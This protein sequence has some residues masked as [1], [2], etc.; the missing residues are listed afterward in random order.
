MANTA[1]NLYPVLETPRGFPDPDMIERA[2]DEADFNRAVQSYRFFYPTVSFASVYAGPQKIGAVPNK[3]FGIL[4]GNPTQLVFTA[5]SDTPYATVLLDLTDSPAVIELPPGPLIGV[6]NDLNQR[7]VM[8]LGVPGP[9]AGKGGKHVII[10]PDY[11]GVIPENH[12][13]GHSTTRRLI[14]AV[15]VIPENGDIEAAV[16]RMKDIKIT[17]LASGVR[18]GEQQ[19]VD[20][21]TTF[22]DTTPLQ[23]ENN[24]RFWEVLHEVIDAEPAFEGYRNQYGE[25][26]ALGIEKGKPFSPDPRMKGILERAAKSGV[27]QM[28]VQAFADRR[29][30][31]V[32]WKDRRWE[33]LCLRPDTTSF[34]TP[35]FTDLSAREKWFYQAIL[36]SPAMTRRKVGSGSVY[37]LG[38]RDKNG[39]WLDG[40]K[41]YKLTVPLPV[42]AK[43]FWSVTVYDA[44]TRSEIQTD[45]KNAALRSLFEV[46]DK[47]KQ[48]SVDLYFGPTPPKGHENEWIKTI[49]G[50]GWFSYFRVYGPDAEALN[51]KWK[52]ADF[53][54]I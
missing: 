6:A 22:Q 5:N 46:K 43:L 41:T 21:S 26:A 31:R 53:E 25:L 28:R 3:V 45:Q 2:Y 17:P 15:R 4:K 52:P 47:L 34:D 48:S 1:K 36:E 42:P 44:E 32:V 19:W 29:P 38:H 12:F 40:D 13:I 50:K 51:G 9:D 24:I 11:K 54:R 39:T 7:W 8:D 14:L 20:I 33:W 49:P 23:Y 30:E 10:P 35:N 27:E 18:W 37:W 16:A